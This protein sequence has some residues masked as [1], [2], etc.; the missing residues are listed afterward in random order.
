MRPLACAADRDLQVT[1]G[2]KKLSKFPGAYCFSARVNDS[3]SAAS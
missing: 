1:P 3:L 2:T